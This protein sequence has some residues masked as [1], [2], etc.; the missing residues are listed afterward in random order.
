MLRLPPRSSGGNVITV[1]SPI[2][3]GKQAARHELYWARFPNAEARTQNMPG[4]RRKVWRPPHKPCLAAGGVGL[5]ELVIVLSARGDPPTGGFCAADPAATGRRRL[6]W[7]NAQ[8][9]D[10]QCA[11]IATGG[12]GARGAGA[13]GLVE[14]G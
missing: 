7:A 10:M 1:F 4:A 6:G 2:E 5:R 12:A 14:C 3:D 8:V 9:W 13:Y 11:M